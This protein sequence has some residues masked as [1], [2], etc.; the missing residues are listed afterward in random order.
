MFKKKGGASHNTIAG[1]SI[2]FDINKGGNMANPF[3]ES[4]LLKRPGPKVNLH[5]LDTIKRGSAWP[6]SNVDVPVLLKKMA[7][8]TY[9][10]YEGSITSPPCT[11]GVRWTVFEKV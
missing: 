5:S 4:L 11:E 1:V 9:W 10:S 8:S 7:R 3:I 6:V 2:F